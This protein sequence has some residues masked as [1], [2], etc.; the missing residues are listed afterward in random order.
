M[1]PD[2]V[3]LGYEVGS[4]EPVMLPSHHLV[5]TG[6]TRLSGKTTTLEAL[7]TRANKTSLAFIT[8]RGESLLQGSPRLQP[9]FQERSD[10]QFVTL[11]LEA[12]LRE[13]LKM[14][15]S[16]IIRVTKGTSS[17][18]G[19]K[20]KVDEDLE[21]PK[22]RGFNRDMLTNL[23]AYLEIVL[24]Q[25]EAAPLT[26]K[27]DLQDGIPQVMDLSSYAEEVQVLIIRSV[28]EEIYTKHQNVTLVLPEAHK[29]I[30]QGYRTPAKP[31]LEK[32]IR[33]GGSLDLWVWLDSQDIAG[34]DKSILKQC[35]IWLLGRQ[36]ELNEAKHA[37]DQVPLPRGSRPKI[38][39]IM[40]LG[41]GQFFA[42]FGSE[43]HKVYVQPTWLS[44]G[45]ARL[46]AKGAIAPPEAPPVPDVD[47]EDE[48][49]RERA[50]VAEAALAQATAELGEVKQQL[51]TETILSASATAKLEETEALLERSQERAKRDEKLVMALE[52]F[53]RSTMLLLG[54]ERDGSPTFSL[55]DAVEQVMERLPAASDGP[56][57]LRLA[58]VP[59]LQEVF[60]GT[61][62]EALRVRAEELVLSVKKMPPRRKKML[63]VLGS[64]DRPASIHEAARLL[65]QDIRGSGG[66]RDAWGEEMRI[67]VNEKWA[68][69]DPN[70]RGFKHRIALK[71]AEDLAFWT[72]TEEDIDAVVQNILAEA[73]EGLGIEPAAAS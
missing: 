14:E 30:P 25:L 63:A 37:L 69:K 40:N 11:L 23:G 53:R 43:V 6:I 18:A 45:E 47:E 38:D 39:E 13:R 51:D 61:V 49:Y 29:T 62:R 27:L 70:K 4:G 41:V 72:P 9:F 65:G 59:A 67:L 17:L 5:V 8:K 68:Y 42:C 73:A 26:Q 12:T 48:M 44:E 46:V 19:V 2:S 31:V 10:W 33:E 66:A 52:D 58:P 34:V 55:D 20:A 36:R 56:T 3:L 16:T 15:R 24:P 54:I 50:R 21:D 7:L 28:V 57:V 60:A 22:I 35:D 32:L 71:V 1:P 64:L